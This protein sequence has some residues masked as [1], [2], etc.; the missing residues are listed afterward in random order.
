MSTDHVVT[1]NLPGDLLAQLDR[2]A[3]SRDRSRSWAI[4]QAVAEWVAEEQ[5]R[6]E[7]TLEGL[8]CIDDGRV[9][10]QQEIEESFADTKRMRKAAQNV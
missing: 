7:L 2:F 8:Q 9:L 4:R 10:T 5:R 6:H 1:A 3:A